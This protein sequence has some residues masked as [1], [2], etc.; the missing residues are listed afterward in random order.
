[1]AVAAQHARGR[2]ARRAVLL[3]KHVVVHAVAL[4]VCVVYGIR[5]SSSSSVRQY[6]QGLDSCNV[7]V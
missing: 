6:R 4:H 2:A 1:M 7:A 3:Q 5:S